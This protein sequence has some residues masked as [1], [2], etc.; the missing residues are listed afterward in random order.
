MNVEAI[1]NTVIRNP[2]PTEAPLRAP[3]REHQP[4]ELRADAQAN[5]PP[6]VDRAELAQALDGVNSFLAS[7]NNHIQFA[8]H[9]GSGKMMVE[10]IDNAT[11]EIIK[12]FPSKE[13][14][15]LASKIGELLGTLMDRKG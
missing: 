1:A 14:L 7:G 3:Q 15:D 8:L 10:V 12:T 5:E 11:E 4:V 13:L 6:E 2:P 9:E